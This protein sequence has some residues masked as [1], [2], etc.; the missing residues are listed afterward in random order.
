METAAK[1][2][3]SCQAQ[4]I[5]LFPYRL[6]GHSHS[7]AMTSLKVK[8]E[9]EAKEQFQCLRK[10]LPEVEKSCC[11][12]Y[13]EIGFM[14][15]RISAHVAKSHIDMVIIGQQQV[16]AGNDNYGSNI[17]SLITIS[18]IPFVIVP[19]KVNAEATVYSVQKTQL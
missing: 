10:A 16:N 14:T 11:E 8:L 6:I 9:S 7:G 3:N 19:A 2:A 4:L 15:D 13:A 1:I 5:V 17:Q 18:E 12:F